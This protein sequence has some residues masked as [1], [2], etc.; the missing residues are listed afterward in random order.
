VFT[1]NTMLV[2]NI[3][4]ISLSMHSVKLITVPEI[5]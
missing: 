2:C 5:P 1:I 3:F 4:K